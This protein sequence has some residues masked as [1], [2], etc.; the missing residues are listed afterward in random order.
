LRLSL[1]GDDSYNL[2]AVRLSLILPTLDEREN[3]ER[4]VPLLLDEIPELGEII[5]VDDG[6]RDGTPQAVRALAEHDDRVRLLEHRGR[7]SL[8]ES[9]E[10]GIRGARERLIG[11]MDAD[12]VMLPSDLRRLIAEVQRGAD[13]AVASRFAP[14]GRIKGQHMDGLVGR[15][16]ALGNLH[17]T[18]DSWLG[19]ALSWA[20]NAVV[21]PAIVGDGIQDY[22]SGIIVAKRE[23][24]EG[25]RLFGRHG[26]YFIV[27]WTELK[28]RG[29]TIVDMP[30]RVQPRKHGRSKT[31]NDL[32][33]Y[34][35]RG[36]AYLR[37]GLEAR[38]RLL[39]R[40][41]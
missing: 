39:A 3:V 23:A 21:L 7:P 10:Q 33:D 32:V 25:M 9:L 11:W 37:A 24:L 34:T 35:R 28:A 16:Q 20:L 19:V 26:E 13:V 30:Y 5:V 27:L 22:T 38:R 2:L 14:G 40:S 12:L 15:I 8:A 41:R 18:E 36:A 4:F 1:V 29:F 6:S 31:G 17:T